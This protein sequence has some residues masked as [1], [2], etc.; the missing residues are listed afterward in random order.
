MRESP[1]AH[2]NI[3]VRLLL[4]QALPLLGDLGTGVTG[5]EGG[6]LCRRRGEEQMQDQLNATQFACFFVVCLSLPRD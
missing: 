1:N 4:H 3:D 5:R 6:Q 2:L